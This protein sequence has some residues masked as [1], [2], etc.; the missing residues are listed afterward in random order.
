MVGSHWR[1]VKI[2]TLA[3][4]LPNS[5][6]LITSLS[7]N[8]IIPSLGHTSCSY[9]QGLSALK[10]GAGL[11]THLYNAMSPFHHR[12]PSLVGLSSQMPFSII[13]D[14]VHVHPAAV[15]LAF[16]GNRVS[17]SEEATFRS[18]ISNVVASL[19]VLDSV[20]L[21]QVWLHPSD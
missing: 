19:L 15:N 12:K 17:G 3:P 2:V 18:R 13:S 11:I 9:D 21:W 1:S 7:S 8:F 6:D 16:Q 14:G 10:N 5:L 20:S 4:E